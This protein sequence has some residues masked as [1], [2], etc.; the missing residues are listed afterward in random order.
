MIFRATKQPNEGS[1]WRV[2]L[3]YTITHALCGPEMR[4]TKFITPVFGDPDSPTENL[5]G[6]GALAAELASE[7][8]SVKDLFARTGVN[9]VQLEDAYARISYRQRLAI[10]R[11]AKPPAKRHRAAGRRAAEDQRLRDI[12]VWDGEQP[13]LRR[14]PDVFASARHHGRVLRSNSSVSGSTAER[15]FCAATAS[16]PWAICCRLPPSSGEDT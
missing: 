2:H 1:E 5:L 7:G 11:N 14:R 9:V 16:I 10:Y 4:A 13:D 3:C 15:R 12:R 6:L 8:V